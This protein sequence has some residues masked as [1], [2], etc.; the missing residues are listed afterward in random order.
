MNDMIPRMPIQHYNQIIA[1]PG[2]WRAFRENLHNSPFKQ[3]LDSPTK[4]SSEGI[5]RRLQKAL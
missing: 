1:I 5:L 2:N 3:S 4:H